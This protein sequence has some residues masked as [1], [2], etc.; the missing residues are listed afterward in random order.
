MIREY[1][2]E[3]PTGKVIPFDE[4]A[5]DSE[6]N[7]LTLSDGAYGGKGRGLAFMNSLKAQF[8]LR[9]AVK[10]IKIRIPK[11]ALIGAE[12][13]EG[14]LELNEFVFFKEDPP[15]YDKVKRFFLKGKLSGQLLERLDK[16]LDH[17]KKP[18]A[19]RSSG[20]FEDSI[21]QPFAGIF[22][23]YI[24]PNNHE[25][26]EERL[27]QLTDAIKLVFASVFSDK[28]INY[29][30]ALNNKLGEEKMAVV[31]QELVGN[32]YNGVY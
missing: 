21:S 4:S 18:L 1:R 11:T 25:N 30:K 17:Y 28:A 13:F 9:D 31:I 26:K 5:C 12:E 3:Q 24:L 6:E 14:F 8:N 15:E 29:T 2:D 10:G 7:I 16:L 27:R 22:E 20:L 19:I 32:Q 23:T